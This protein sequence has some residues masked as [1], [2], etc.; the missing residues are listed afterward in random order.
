[1]KEMHM[2]SL[3]SEPFRHGILDNTQE[4][5]GGFFGHAQASH[6]PLAAASK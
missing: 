1:M 4:S 6:F 2:S 3:L 5:Q